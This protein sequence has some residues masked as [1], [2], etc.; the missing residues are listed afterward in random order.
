MI[1]TLFLVEVFIFLGSLIVWGM[2]AMVSS[3]WKRYIH[4]LCLFM[5]PPPPGQTSMC[6]YV[7][8]PFL[9]LQ[10]GQSNTSASAD[11]VGYD[12]GVGYPIGSGEVSKMRVN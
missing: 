3:C 10:K 7:K 5:F 11:R 1:S 8:L 9:N 6:W 4:S 2:P 12:A